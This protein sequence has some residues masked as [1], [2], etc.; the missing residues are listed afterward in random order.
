MSGLVTFA[1]NMTE[2]ML[3]AG[4]FPSEI[5]QD[6]ICDSLR[7]PSKMSRLT[8]IVR[9][10]DQVAMAQS[11][12]LVLV[13]C[14]FG[15]PLRRLLNHERCII[16]IIPTKCF[17]KQQQPNEY[18]CKSTR[19]DMSMVLA[20]AGQGSA[21]TGSGI[22]SNFLCDCLAR[23]HLGGQSNHGRCCLERNGQSRSCAYHICVQCSSTDRRK[24]GPGSRRTSITDMAR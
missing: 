1:M 4:Y 11:E 7:K 13:S 19:D 8:S 9:R 2:A 16:S 22:R 17:E 14:P 5:T 18:K 12:L 3:G 10:L 20:A 24:S 23:G 21:G 15:G 6:T